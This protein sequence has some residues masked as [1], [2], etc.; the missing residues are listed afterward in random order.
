MKRKQLFKK[1]I[2]LGVIVGPNAITDTELAVLYHSITVGLGSDLRQIKDL[3]DLI[4]EDSE[5]NMA[6]LTIATS[7]VADT[8]DIL[9]LS[10]NVNDNFRSYII[11]KI[12]NPDPIKYN[13]FCKCGK[14][15]NVI[16]YIKNIQDLSVNFN[17]K[18][19]NPTHICSN[20][21]WAVD[22]KI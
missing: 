1:L 7:S 20:C 15:Q 4:Y 9:N 11:H 16:P 6:L 13:Y 12:T 17:L 2:N 5:D 18:I 3:E 22:L 21:G 10:L 19:E 14:W 8:V